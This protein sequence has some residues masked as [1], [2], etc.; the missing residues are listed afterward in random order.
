MNIEV[1]SLKHGFNEGYLRICLIDH[2]QCQ[3][4]VHHDKQIAIKVP[5]IYMG[6]CW[7][8]ADS[9][10]TILL[11]FIF[12][13]KKPTLNDQI[14]VSWRTSSIHINFDDFVSSA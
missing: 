9:S 4:N 13:G 6:F 3:R 14:M 5:Q 11:L 1:I 12:N 10:L 2:F 8:Y 7:L